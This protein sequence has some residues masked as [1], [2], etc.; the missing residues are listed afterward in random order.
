MAGRAVGTLSRDIFLAPPVPSG[1]M[2]GVHG[3]QGLLQ[4]CFI[5]PGTDELCRIRLD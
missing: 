1:V 4:Y 2:L 3:G 5:V